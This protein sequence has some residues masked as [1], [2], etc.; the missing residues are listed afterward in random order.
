M[1][2][3]V[4]PGQRAGTAVG[5]YRFAGDLG[6]VLGPLVAGAS[7]SALGFKPAFWIASI[8]IGL[9]FVLA[10]RTPETLRAG[11]TAAIPPGSGPAG[12]G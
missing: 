10:I 1:L 11:N 2:S 6:F 12:P 9:G 8:P 4:A 5:L 3:D 7:A